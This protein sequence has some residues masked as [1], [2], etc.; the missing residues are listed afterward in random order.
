MGGVAEMPTTTR[1]TSVG[2]RCTTCGDL[3][4][5]IE[6]GWV[7]WLASEEE[8]GRPTMRGVRLVHRRGASPISGGCQYDVHQEFQSDHSIVE[9]LSLARFVGPD[10]LMLLL[11]LIASGEVSAFEVIEL[12]KRVQIPGYE[13]ARDLFQMA[14]ENGLLSP[15]IGKGFYLQ[16]EIQALL[17]WTANAA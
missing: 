16:S 6:D 14:I 15:S 5:R 7:E 3:I 13:Q 2:W 17:R 9:G 8:S 11:S 4:T 1:R 10:G 12:A